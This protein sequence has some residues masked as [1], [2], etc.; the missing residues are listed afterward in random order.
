[1]LL[2][3]GKLV[4]PELSRYPIVPALNTLR[5]EHV[6]SFLPVLFDTKMYI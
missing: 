6:P 4:V 3:S 5:V 1:M 2:P